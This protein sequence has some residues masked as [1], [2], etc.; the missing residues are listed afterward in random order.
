MHLTGGVTTGAGAFDT[1][2]SVHQYVNGPANST[3]WEVTLVVGSNVS[4]GGG[5]VQLTAQAICAG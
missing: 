3:T 5:T 4:P 2:A 1:P